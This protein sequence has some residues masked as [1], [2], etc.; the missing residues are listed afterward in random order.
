M[1]RLIEDARESLVGK[2][3]AENVEPCA[4]KAAT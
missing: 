3:R 1:T 4:D 2:I